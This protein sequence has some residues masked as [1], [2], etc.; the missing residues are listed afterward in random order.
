MYTIHI[1]DYQELRKKYVYDQ[2]K[3]SRDDCFWTKEQ[4]LI[5]SQIYDTFST[6]VCPMRAF[7]LEKMG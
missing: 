6:K 4:E 7:D 5:M 1:S 3:T 2:R